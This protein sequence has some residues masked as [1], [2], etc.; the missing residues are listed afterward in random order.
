MA[1][2]KPVYRKFLN[3]LL[4]GERKA[5]NRMVRDLLNDKIT[6]LD[7]YVLL[8]Q[9]SLYEVG[10][11]WE[12][13]KISVAKEHLATAITEGLLNLIYSELTAAQQRN[14]KVIV[15]CA[16]NEY[17]Q[18]GGKMVA[19]VFESNGWDA[20][21]L[22]ANT[23]IGHLLE[24]ID[25]EKPDLVALSLT[26]YFNLPSLKNA[27]DRIAVSFPN[28]DILVGGQVFLHTGP[29]VLKSLP[30]VSFVPDLKVLDKM[31]SE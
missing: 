30:N 11:L 16:A 29:G 18:I 1:I 5:L 17:H 7:L 25:Q 26:I 14:R 6:I 19:D 23:P 4:N 2:T 8:F 22:G 21:F 10:R 15:S 24:H 12:T 20:Q 27:I 31:A 13:N 28:L 9:K 3:H